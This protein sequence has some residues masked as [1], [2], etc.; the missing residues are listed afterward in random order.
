[1]SMET[2]FSQRTL[3][4]LQSVSMCDITEVTER[5]HALQ[6]NNL[7]HT[8]THKLDVTEEAVD[9]PRQHFHP[10]VCVCQILLITRGDEGSFLSLTS[11]F[12]LRGRQC[13][14]QI[15]HYIMILKACEASRFDHTCNPPQQKQKR[16]G[17]KMK[18]WILLTS[19]ISYWELTY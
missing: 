19:F 7:T 15:L 12:S 2:P 8:Y 11:V 17:R 13:L 3:C 5:K 4:V 1:M 6:V 16:R 10:N 14:H 18:T 9:L